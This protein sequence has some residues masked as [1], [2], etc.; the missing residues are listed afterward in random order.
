[1]SLLVFLLAA[2]TTACRP[3]PET[4]GALVVFVSIPPQAYLV[5][6][7]G[8]EH[9]SV[10]VL[11]QTSQDPHT[12]EPTPKQMMALAKATLFFRSGMPFE[13]GLVEKISRAHRR[14]VVINPNE[15][16]PERRLSEEETCGHVHDHEFHG[17]ELDPHTWLAPPVIT[18][19][20]RNIAAALMRADPDHAGEYAR[21]LDALLEDIERVHTWI[22]SVLAPYK[23]RSFYVFHPAFGYFADAY[24]LKQQA[25]EIEGKRPTPKRLAEFI[26]KAKAEGVNVV[27]VQPQ[28]DKKAA[29]AVAAAI[30]SALV[31]MDPLAKDVLKNLEEVATK[32]ENAL[33]TRATS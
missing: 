9:V 5:E 26:K 14:L 33:R 6:R 17:E 30:G 20:A 18:I 4:G 10:R 31:P 19:Q 15:G 23:G 25:V 2:L 27:F 22:Q 3:S 1:M 29:E 28:F 24:G 11:V 21:N 8:G 7:I 16:I 13:T 32:I 12:F